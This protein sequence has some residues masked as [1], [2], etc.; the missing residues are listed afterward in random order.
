MGVKGSSNILPKPIKLKIST[1]EYR[2]VVIDAFP[3]I[4]RW[5]IGSLNSGKYIANDKNEHVPEIF[6]LFKIAIRFLADNIV[7]IFVFDGTSPDIK[8]STD[9][10]RRINKK[11]ADNMLNEKI[12]P[13]SDDVEMKCNDSDS[14]SSQ[15]VIRY[16][17][18]SYKIN[19]KNMK[20]A[21]FLLKWMG[22]PVIDAPCEADAQCAAIA[23]AYPNQVIGVLTDD[24][25]PLMF[26]SINILKIPRLISNDI[27]EYRLDGTL[28]NLNNKFI[29]VI[30]KSTNEKIKQQLEMKKVMFTLD[31]LLDIG[32]LM[33]TDYCNGLKF[34]GLTLEENTTKILELYAIHN[35]DINKLLDNHRPKL[36]ESH[37]DK[38][39]NAKKYY[40]TSVIT[41]PEKIKLQF[42]KPN[43][44]MIRE[45]CSEI[46][47][48]ET[49]EIAIE[50]VNSAYH[51]WNQ[52]DQVCETTNK[53]NSCS[54][55]VKKK[56]HRDNQKILPEPKYRLPIKLS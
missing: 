1:C 38:I 26:G 30:R 37:I 47:N 32:C 42:R 56:L 6:Y 36:K 13:K 8:S 4:Y 49:L 11:K 12:N 48:Q 27:D 28:V 45:I 18:R 19:R 33:G 10:R 50:I 29:Q 25:D 16:L 2:M 15:Q 39:L 46:I 43:E 35:M 31:N 41:H 34:K 55:Y 40:T 20:I 53:S 5:V 44:M 7:P 54:R 51:K 24:F 22:V 17:K 14:M 23:L 21:K 52:I 3:I 9:D